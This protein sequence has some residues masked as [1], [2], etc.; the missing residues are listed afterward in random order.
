MKITMKELIWWGWERRFRCK[1][2]CHG[3]TVFFNSTRSGI[4]HL[5]Y[6]A[7]MTNRAYPLE[8]W[9]FFVSIWV[10][11]KRITCVYTR[12]CL[13]LKMWNLYSPLKN[14]FA[15]IR[16][17]LTIKVVLNV[18]R[19]FCICKSNNEENLWLKY[20]NRYSSPYAKIRPNYVHA[21]KLT[22]T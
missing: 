16:Y 14:W 21:Y 20:E 12:S 10:H 7:E 5:P 4:L 13:S 15:E 1:L 2:C 3:R 8:M 18:S 22:L 11:L 17:Y 6:N 9:V 19:W